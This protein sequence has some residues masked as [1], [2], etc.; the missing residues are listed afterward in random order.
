MPRRI[1][2]QNLHIQ[3]SIRPQLDLGPADNSLLHGVAPQEVL[4]EKGAERSAQKRADDVNP[5]PSLG[6]GNGHGPPYVRVRVL[7]SG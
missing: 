6:T 1:E 5:K 7:Q 2:L 4:C 3:T